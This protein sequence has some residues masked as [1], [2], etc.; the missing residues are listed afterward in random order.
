MDLRKE[1]SCM[2]QINDYVFYESGGICKVADIRYAPLESM[3]SDRRY[4]ILQSTHDSNGV[5]YVPVDNDCI[6]MRRLFNRREAEDFLP[7]IPSIPVIEE[8]NAKLLRNK[9]T[10][11]MRTHAPKEWVRV[12]K[13]VY[14]RAMALSATRSARLS[15]TERSFSETA[16]RY[17]YTELALALEK[18]PHDMENY[19][20]TYFEKAE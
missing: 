15:E 1:D 14:T 18:D 4:Y 20:V 9:Y 6:F 13:T 3:P 7:T 8:S 19:L 5:M 10:E 11:A 16:K 2:Y 12:I 17:L